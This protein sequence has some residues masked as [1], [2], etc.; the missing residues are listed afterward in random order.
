MGIF[1]GK[2]MAKLKNT[3]ASW[4]VYVILCEGRVLFSRITTDVDR[5]LKEQLSGG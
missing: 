4:Y 2:V 1:T 3:N 5:K